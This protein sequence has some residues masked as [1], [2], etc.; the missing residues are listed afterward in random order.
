MITSAQVPDIETPDQM[1]G[2]GFPD[3]YACKKD[4]DCVVVQGP[5]AAISAVHVQHKTAYEKQTHARQIRMSCVIKPS[6]L[7]SYRAVCE[8]TQCR[9]KPVAKK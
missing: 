1:I 2:E 8:N 9:V 6:D 5:C 4:S 7:R 3:L